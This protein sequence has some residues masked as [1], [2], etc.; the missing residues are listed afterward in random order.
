MS[1]LIVDKAI[2]PSSFAVVKRVRGLLARPGAV[3][4][5]VGHG[6]TLDP[7]ASGVLPICIGEGTKVLP[8]LLDADKSYDAVIRFGVET[9]TLD[10]TGR[11]VRESAVT[12]LSAAA[13]ADA[14]DSFRGTIKQVPPMF[15]ALKRQGRPLYVYARA[16]ETI[17]RP[18]RTVTVHQLDLVWFEP[19]DR[20]RIRLRC[21]KGTYVRSLA[22]DLGHRL[23]V[24]AHLVELRR[25]ASGPFRIEQAVTLEE[26]AARV[27]RNE[28]L[29]LLTPLEALAHLPTLA[30]DA[31]Q[32]LVLERGQRMTWSVL[33]A[34]S[35][36]RGP[37]CA[38]LQVGGKAV[39]VAVVS[40]NPDGGVKILRGFRFERSGS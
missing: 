4:E 18:A 15:S 22:A 33:C 23:Q 2:G 16:G 30:V 10:V 24:G 37:A 38:V 13:V 39:L 34:D 5:R 19:P 25:T 11:V 1:L 40:E 20:A 28:P 35:A 32:A 27:A 29:P 21:S 14:L 36:V 7:F 6:G 12:G 17:E 3:R 9:D 31:A 8:F 26:L